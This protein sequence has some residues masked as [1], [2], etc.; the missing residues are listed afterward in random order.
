MDERFLT[1]LYLSEA[2]EKYG[3]RLDTHCRLNQTF[4]A[5]VPD[6]LWLD[7]QD[8]RITNKIHDTK[9]VFVH[10]NGRTRIPDG[11]L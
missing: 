3:I 7:V 2:R 6:E 8:K 1:N 10:F 4:L 11:L 9:P 5:S